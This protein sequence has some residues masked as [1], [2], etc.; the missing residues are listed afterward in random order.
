MNVEVDVDGER[1]TINLGEEVGWPLLNW[2]R[3]RADLY[4][5]L[6]DKL[7]GAELDM[8]LGKRGDGIREL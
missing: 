8:V 5:V 3:I 6:V 7:L 2:D 4:V 1:R